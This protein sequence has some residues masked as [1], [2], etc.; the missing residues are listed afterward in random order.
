MNWLMPE[1]ASDIRAQ[2]AALRD[3]A[4]P[5]SVLFAAP[6]NKGDLPLEP[7]L[8]M[9]LTDRPWGA[10]V[11][12]DH[13]TAEAFSEAMPDDAAMAR[14]LGYPEP[15]DAARAACPEAW[16][17]VVQACDWRGNVVTE[18]LCSPKWLDRT[19]AALNAHGHLR[20][21][22]PADALGR[23]LALRRAELMLE[24]G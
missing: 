16:L 10:L 23:R 3:H 8:G 4:H 7:G 18:A 11:T 21:L 17:R 1:P 5:K 13:E 14:I 22:T 15:K 24:T 6:G 20:V 19:R 12:P 2:I 9:V